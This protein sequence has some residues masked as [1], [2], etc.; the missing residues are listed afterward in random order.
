MYLYKYSEKV[1]DEVWKQKLKIYD[2][3]ERI[4]EKIFNTILKKD[5]IGIHCKIRGNHKLVMEEAKRD[6]GEIRITVDIIQSNVYSEAES[7]I[8]KHSKRNYFIIGPK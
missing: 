4:N 2:H 8:S 7:T 6:A 1:A 5:L 3:L